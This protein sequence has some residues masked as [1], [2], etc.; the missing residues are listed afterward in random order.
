VEIG[1]KADNM[2]RAARQ[3]SEEGGVD[4]DLPLADEI[5]RGIVQVQAAFASGDSEQIESRT[6]ELEK[7]VKALRR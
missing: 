5:E 3:A 7:L 6:Q 4:G 2:V 1:I